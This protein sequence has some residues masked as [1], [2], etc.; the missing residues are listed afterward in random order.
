LRHSPATVLVVDD[1]PA[2][3]RFLK[4]TL[5]AQG[6]AMVEAA[7]ADEAT[8]AVR[9]HRP[10]IILLDLGLPDRDGMALLPELKQLSDA[11]I[12]VLT[13]RDDE[14]SIVAALDGG[15]DDYIT[16]PFS[17]P[18]LLARMRAALRHRVQEQGGRP[19]VQAGEITVDLVLRR[20]TRAGQE[21]KLSPKEWD[22]LEQLAIHL[23]R[24]V[25]HGQI[26]AKVWGRA[27]ETEHQY[28]RVYLRQLRQKL[29]PDP[30]RPRWLLTEPGVGYRLLADRE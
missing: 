26:L 4:S 19:S 3:R 29:E 10:E 11:A 9:H 20:V 5:E 15:A 1:E 2:I 8:R 27:T 13:S 25:T 6:W 30:A 14:R 16:K 18:E 22:I 24:V 23:G 21:I 12:L 7:T 28:L 17:I